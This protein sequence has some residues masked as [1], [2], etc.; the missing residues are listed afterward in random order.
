MTRP[1][2][3]SPVVQ[4]LA[5]VGVVLVGAAGVVWSIGA[6]YYF[7]AFIVAATACGLLVPLYP[8]EEESDGFI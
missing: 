6:G 1:P 7:T 2:K 5:G 8:D 3:L 4:S